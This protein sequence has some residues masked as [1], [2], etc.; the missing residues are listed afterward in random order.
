MPTKT[1]FQ[2]ENT[3]YNGETNIGQ[4]FNYGPV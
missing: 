1:D 3:K 4:E 2:P